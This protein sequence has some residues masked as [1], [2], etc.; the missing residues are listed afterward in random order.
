MRSDKNQMS[1]LSPSVLP[2]LFKWIGRIDLLCSA[3][4]L[5]AAF[6][7]AGL[8]ATSAMRAAA[9]RIE[10]PAQARI[11]RADWARLLATS[12]KASGE[13]R[14]EAVRKLASPLSRR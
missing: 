13:V 4:D 8:S 11:H 1:R 14:G 5:K 7:E 2:R 6:A 10:A 12:T 9:T 3:A